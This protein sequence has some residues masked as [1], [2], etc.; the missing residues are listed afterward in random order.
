[1]AFNEA[2]NEGKSGTELFNRKSEL[3]EKNG[4]EYAVSAIKKFKRFCKGD[5]MALDITDKPD[6]DTCKIFLSIK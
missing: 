2:T 4:G 6:S 1:M 3:L 5:D